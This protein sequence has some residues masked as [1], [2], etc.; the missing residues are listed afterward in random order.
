MKR[1]LPGVWLAVALLSPSVSGGTYK[2]PDEKPIVSI[3]I[4][5]NWKTRTTEEYVEAISPDGA[6]QVLVIPAEVHK[7]NESIGEV[8]RYLRGKTGVIVNAE[9]V[10]EE[11]TKI[12]QVAARSVS[13]DGKDQ[14]GDVKI[15]FTVLSLAKREPLLFAS[16]GA[17]QAAEMHRFILKKMLESIKKV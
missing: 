8:M 14:K 17:P 3:R 16:W 10:H 4:P 15:T 7:I 9:S 1:L 12:N 2:V 6:L 11:S 13:W 5:D